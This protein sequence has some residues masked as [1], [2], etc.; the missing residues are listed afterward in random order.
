M[1]IFL[2]RRL[3]TSLLLLLLVLTILFFFLRLLPGDPTRTS[4][5]QRLTAEQRHVL[6]RLERGE[7]TVA[8]AERLLVGGAPEREPWSWEEPEEPRADETPEEAEARALV[9]RI[10]QEIDAEQRR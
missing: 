9:E 6:E 8:Q 5:G 1:T 7:L 3:G 4:E 10:A 2:L